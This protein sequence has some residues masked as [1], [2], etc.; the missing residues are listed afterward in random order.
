MCGRYAS[1][2]PPEA[3]ARLCR[4]TGAL[5]NVAPSWNVAPSHQAMVVRRHPETGERHIDLLTWG[6]V[7][8]W[9]KDLRAARRPIN[10]RAETVATSPMFPHAFARRRALIPAQAF[11]EWQRTG[12]GSKQ[13]FAIAR[14]DGETLAFAG[15]W[16]GWR[17]PEG[18]VLRSFAIIVTAANATMAPI[19]DRMP[20]ILAP[21][22][23]P[24]W[25]GETE[26][27]AASLLH[28]A[29]GD[30]LRVWPVSTRVNR[31]ANNDAD[32]L[33]PLLAV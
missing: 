21:K 14:R 18:E 13:P 8:P 26:G 31:P 10:A 1:F 16:D 12:N 30:T 2:L 24:L 25:L 27:D 17:S 11:Y 33:A 22:H 19:H 29:S 23:W 9:T 4:T 28:P 32:L 15:L 20:V 5:P 3:I 6:L 7:P